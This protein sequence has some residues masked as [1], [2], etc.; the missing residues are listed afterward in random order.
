MSARTPALVAAVAIGAL[1]GLAPVAAASTY[2]VT[3]TA[4]ST[5]PCSGTTCPSLRSAVAAAVAEGGSTV[6]L[7]SGTYKLGNGAMQVVGD[8]E[9]KITGGVKLVGA[10][11]GATTI[12]QTDGVHRVLEVTTGAVAISG[13]TITGGSITGATGVSP[14]TPGTDVTGGG[15]LN[16]GALSLDDVRVTGNKA[17]GGPGGSAANTNGSAGGV[18]KGGGV[19]TAGTLTLSHSVVDLNVTTGGGGGGTGTASGGPA[20]DALGAVYISAS[21]TGPVTVT[22]SVVSS[23]TS[24][25]GAGGSTGGGSSVGASGDA[26]GG[27]V[28]FGQTLTVAGSTVSG[29]SATGGAGPDEGSPVGGSGGEGAG[30]GIAGEAGTLVVTASTISGNSSV[31]GKGGSSLGSSGGNGGD[32]RGGGIYA[33]TGAT[34]VNTTISGNL[35]TPGTGGAGHVTP[36]TAGA[37]TGGGIDD[38]AATTVT[39]ASVTLAPNSSGGRAGNVYT[40]GAPLAAANTIIA[41]GSAP[42]DSNC[43]PAAVTSDGGHNLDSTS[44]CGLAAAKQDVVGADPL[45]GALAD[46]GGPTMTMAPGASSPVLGAG[47]ACTDPL[48]GNGALTSDQR[49]AAR[50]ATCDIGAFQAQR[51]QGTGVP[52]VS[53]TPAPGQVLSCTP[54]AWTGD[55]PLV[56]AYAWLKDGAEIVGAVATQ[57][58][59]GA[60]A[61][62]QIACRVTATSPYGSAVQTSAPVLVPGLV[63]PPDTKPP[64]I[65]GLSLKPASFRVGHSTR[66]SFRLSEAAR[67][68]FTVQRRTIGHRKGKRCRAGRGKRGCVRYVAVKGHLVRT[69]KAGVNR[70]HWKGRLAGS[71]LRP[72]RYRLVGVA[73]D[74]AAN[75]SRKPARRAFRVLAAAKRRR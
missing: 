46:N 39:L 19:A 21:S 65:S 51:P 31:G 27:I 64:T 61:G 12:Q 71:K 10:G 44:Q 8:G 74:A 42:A 53:G 28:Q 26:T 75:R 16:N 9:L 3:D 59:V 25:G 1:L 72:G 35:V 38:R 6:M 32:A 66:V 45:L 29:N 62:H 11:S 5:A 22:D 70:F 50:T 47:G 33:L 55:A 49:G 43:S 4:D 54:G 15:I 60:D 23:N 68:T 13:L 67:A 30:G 57:Y 48:N 14:S 56:F 40:N 36:G 69:G 24:T 41:A 18:A 58:T 63:T 52:Q 37:A 2:T 7:G 20:G 17:T 73:V 34:L